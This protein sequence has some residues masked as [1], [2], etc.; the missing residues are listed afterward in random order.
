MFIQKFFNIGNGSRGSPRL[1]AACRRYFKDKNAIMVKEKHRNELVL[2]DIEFRV[3]KKAPIIKSNIS[4]MIVHATTRF[5]KSSVLSYGQGTT[6]PIGDAEFLVLGYLGI[7][8]S[9][10]PNPTKVDEIIN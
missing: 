8:L 2:G 3:P 1:I 4:D 9:K 5:S 7:P 10:Y 6:S